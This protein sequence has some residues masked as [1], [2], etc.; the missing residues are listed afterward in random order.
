MFAFNRRSFSHTSRYHK[1][2]T[3]SALGHPRKATTIMLFP[4]LRYSL[5]TRLDHRISVPSARSKPRLYNKNPNDPQ[6]SQPDYA[7][8][9]SSALVHCL[10]IIPDTP[11]LWNTFWHS[12][13]AI[14]Q[15]QWQRLKSSPGASYP[16]QTA[17]AAGCSLY[18][19]SLAIGCHLLCP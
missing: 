14:N 10:S 18:I 4:C 1:K 8:V 11:P 5:L 7:K 16:S 9:G 13:Q 12:P 17:H 3:Q 19:P 15:H 6:T 2:H